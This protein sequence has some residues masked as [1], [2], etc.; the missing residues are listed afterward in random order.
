[1][2]KLGWI[3]PAILISSCTGKQDPAPP[4]NKEKM[5]TVLTDLTLMEATLSIR[6]ANGK[7]IEAD[8]T[9]RFNI[10]KEHSV[11]K[12]AYDSSV[13]YYSK[14]PAEFK[15]IYDKVQENLEQLKSK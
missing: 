3:A 14:H 8:S 13:A 7:P 10:Y 4:L 11:S 2:T 6:A 15:E 9:V 1:M 5:A 12:G